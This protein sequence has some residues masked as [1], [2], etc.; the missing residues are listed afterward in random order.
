MSSLSK[1]T[2]EFIADWAEVLTVVLAFAS[3]ICG[4]ILVIANR[5]LKRI[6]LLESEHEKQKTADAQR[7][8]AQ[9][10][11]ALRRAAEYAATP[12]RIIMDTRIVNGNNDHELRA[13]ALRELSK[14]AATPAVILYVQ[15]EEA[16]IL[17]GDIRAA[18]IKAGWKSVSILS[19][20]STPVPPGFVTGGVQI[21]T[22][23]D[24]GNIPYFPPPNAAPPPVATALFDLLKL[25]LNSPVGSPFG[26]RWEP[27]GEINGKH[28][29]GLAR[30][31]FNF[32]KN[33]VVISVGPKPT[34]QLFWGIPD[35]PVANK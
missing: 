29:T 7:A 11:L 28:L 30:Y 27:E 22:W 3:A 9:A 12:R 14:Y 26:V 18:L 32:P 17:A 5:P 19:L 10:Q 2:L 13:A 1:E 6:E 8:A 21:R 31:G 15:D 16:Q 35:P 34:E 4:V 25:D 24:G 33:G 20:S 23:L